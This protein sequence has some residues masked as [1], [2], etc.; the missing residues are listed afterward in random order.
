MSTLLESK[1]ALR[2]RAADVGLSVAEVT[3][4]VDRG[5][6]SLARLAF[7]AAPPRTAPTTE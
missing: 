4:L 3:F 6:N 7:A 1:E 2:S 5:A